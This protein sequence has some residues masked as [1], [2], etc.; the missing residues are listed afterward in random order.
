MCGDEGDR[1]VRKTA[2][3]G[4]LGLNQI[5]RTDTVRV[6]V[7]GCGCFGRFHAQKYT[8]IAGTKLTAVADIDPSAAERAAQEFNADSFFAAE[9]LVG[10]VD[11]VSITTPA[12]CH[13]E[14]A[15]LFLREGI[16]VLA[17]KPIAIDL[18]HADE[19]ISLAEEKQLILQVGHQERFVFENFGLPPLD[20]KPRHIESRRL[21]PFTGRATDVNAV[22]DLMIH[23]LDLLHQVTSSKIVSVHAQG[24]RVYGSHH[25]EVAAVLEL[26]DGCTVDLRVSRASKEQARELRLEYADGEIEVDFI[27]GTLRNSTHAE[28]KPEMNGDGAV[29]KIFNDPLAYG[30]NAFVQSVRNGSPPRISAKE[31]RKALQTACMITERL[32][33]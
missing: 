19:L 22:F 3:I 12:S 28:L 29:H 17:E 31:A 20:L 10:L 15:A 16:H 2:F 13:Y 25:D 26:E 24:K 9:K 5:S 11:A 18:S 7:V 33:A 14:I 6:G 1:C 27:S 8:Q 4:G 32:A 23:D 30:I 21:G